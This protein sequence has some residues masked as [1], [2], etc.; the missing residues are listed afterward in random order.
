MGPLP[1][2]FNRWTCQHHHQIQ[3]RP[4]NELSNWFVCLN[5]PCHHQL[6]RYKKRQMCN[7]RAHCRSGEVCSNSLTT[8]VSQNVYVHKCVYVRVPEHSSHGNEKHPLHCWPDVQ[9]NAPESFIS[10][11]LNIMNKT[12]FT[13]VE[14]Q[15]WYLNLKHI[16]AKLFFLLA[17]I[18][19]GHSLRNIPK[20]MW[21]KLPLDKPLER[22][23]QHF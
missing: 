11:D 21:T 6:Y 23:Q 18:F 9:Y 3:T 16:I 22:L 13:L 7:Y 19:K 10:D 4:W 12:D 20:V 2:L 8:C 15:H 1:A 5:R 14:S 17:P